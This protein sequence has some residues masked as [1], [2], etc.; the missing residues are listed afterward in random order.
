MQYAALAGGVTLAAIA[1]ILFFALPR[2]ADQH[3]GQPMLPTTTLT[4]GNTTLTVELATTP[5]QE[6]QGL[7]GRSRLVEGMGMLFIFDPMKT[8]GFWMKDMRF[9]LDIIFAK[10]DGTIVTIYP[11]LA[12]ATY[13][14]SYHPTEPVRYVLEVPAGFALQH[15]ISVGQKLVLQNQ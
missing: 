8:P 9:S 6:E 10:A 5:E 11:D 1:A 2:S 12:P 13:P 4:I 15:D 3:G 7:S 14:Q